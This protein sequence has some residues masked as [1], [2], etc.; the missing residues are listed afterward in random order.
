[1]YDYN[2]YKYLHD[3]EVLLLRNFS[4]AKKV[5]IHVS[6]VLPESVEIRL[7]V[8]AMTREWTGDALI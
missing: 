1:M 3:E 5:S 2:V 8:H 6:T 7:F 4:Y